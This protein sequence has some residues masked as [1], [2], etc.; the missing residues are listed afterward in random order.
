MKWN[1]V[2]SAN[3]KVVTVNRKARHDYHLME[4]HEA[5]ISL[6]GTE[7]K[8]IRNGGF[9]LT[10]SYIRLEGGEA[11]LVDA[12]IGLYNHSTV[13]NHAP[14]RVRKLLLHRK[15][16]KK[17]DGKTRT[18]GIT[19]VPTKAYFDKGKVKVEIALARGKRDYDKRQ[20][21]KKQTDQ[22]MIR[23]YIKN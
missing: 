11:F 14:K 2:E 19:I 3:S 10:D 13:E 1:K 17:L 21:L 22:R 16:I 9:T 18:S 15:E 7:V 23:D 8:S 4:R 5:G 20:D 12:H 6:T